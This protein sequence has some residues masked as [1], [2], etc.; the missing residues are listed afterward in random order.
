MSLKHWLLLVLFSFCVHSGF[1][2]TH[3]IQYEGKPFFINGINVAWNNFGGD[4]GNHTL[5][6]S[7]YDPIWFDSLFSRCRQYG[8]N[9]VRL[10]IHTDGRATPEFSPDGYVTG[11]DADFYS[12]FDHIFLLAKNH[13]I[14][15]MPCL[16]SFDMCKD[17]RATAG[18]YAGAH[19]DLIQDSTKTQSYIDKV[20]VPM[21]KR[22]DNQCNLLAWEIIN[23]PE[24]AIDRPMDTIWTY[25]TDK[26]VALY[27]MQRFTAMIAA[28]IH[29]NSS[30]MVTTGSAALKYNSDVAP[31]VGNFWSDAALQASY[32]D[33][34]AY[35]DFYQIHYYDYMNAS[36]SDPFDLNYPLSYW[37]LDKPCL[38]GEQP[39]NLTRDTLYTNEEKVQHAYT[40]QYAGHMFWSYNGYDGIGAFDDFK[41]ACKTFY[42]THTDEIFPFIPCRILSSSTLQLNYRTS[43]QK[44]FLQWNA[45]SPKSVQEYD[46]EY[47]VDGKTYRWIQNIPLNEDGDA[48]YFYKIKSG[49]FGYYR[50]KYTE[51]S[52]FTA[53][54]APIFIKP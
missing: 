46:I 23:E 25:K 36:H 41:M 49:A 50:I 39:G 17:E 38:I 51:K 13:G 30:K 4:I 37:Q 54:S 35:V 26:T 8:I 5:W 48:R 22:Y 18:K 53:F 43:G 24:W 19:H 1:A 32:P 52:G 21:V 9:C 44:I 14:L 29:K 28:A 34:A 12:N 42:E 45:E 33:T 7:N 40:N 20:L 16:W 47:S 11:V 27:E 2:Q 15:I 10:W 3:L 6:G 31:A